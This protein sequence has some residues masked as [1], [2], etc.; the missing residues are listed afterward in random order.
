M[1]ARELLGSAIRAYGLYLFVSAAIGIVRAV[2]EFVF[3]DV[4]FGEVFRF[5]LSAS[6]PVVAGYFLMKSS[7]G[8][9]TF[10]RLPSSAPQT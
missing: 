1:S 3:G 8:I 7:E 9:L 6:A 2:I 5:L 4:R 10:M